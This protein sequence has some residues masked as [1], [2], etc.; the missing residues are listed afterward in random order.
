[1]GE[2]ETTAVLLNRLLRFKLSSKNEAH[3]RTAGICSTVEI[4][5]LADLDDVN[6]YSSHREHPSHQL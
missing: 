1:M 5:E 4:V 6:S 2:W 3:T